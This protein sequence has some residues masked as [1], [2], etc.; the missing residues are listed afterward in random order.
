M[1]ENE[2]L[3]V[4]VSY[5]RADAAI[6]DEI[7]AGLEF[8]ERFDVFID[9]DAIHEGEAWQA[10]LQSLIET[11]DAIVF[12]LSPHSASS[13]VCHWEVE[14]AASLS[15]RIIPVLLDS[16][17]EAE[18]PASLS[19]LNY[20]RLD[21]GRSFMEGLAGLRRALL[22]DLEWLREHTRLQQRAVEWNGAGRPEERLLIGEDIKHAKNW[23]QSIPPE[24]PG[25]TQLHR[26]FI[27]ASEAGEEL[28]L[29]EEHQRAEALQ[30]SVKRTRYTRR[31]RRFRC[32]VCGSFGLRLF[33]MAR[34]A[35]VRSNS[36][37]VCRRSDC[38]RGRSRATN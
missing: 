1:A 7:V 20:V 15:K 14:L 32:D 24:A 35:T 6:A 36:S 22:T 19:E 18:A 16:P 13:E 34:C 17:G 12:L 21:E 33:A 29:S 4:F 11:S 30:K 23:L 5:S 25:P 8:A 38:S 3:K 9:R 2:K 27:S 31:S 37:A 26:E 28:R 10:R